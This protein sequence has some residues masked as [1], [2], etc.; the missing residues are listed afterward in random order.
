MR[1][2]V[3]GVLGLAGMCAAVACGSTDSGSDA[4]GGG[5]SANAPG[6]T[7]GETSGAGHAAGA[8]VAA[9]AETTA[10]AAGDAPIECEGTPLACD[11]VSGQEECEHSQGC[12][13]NSDASSCGEDPNSPRVAECAG[14]SPNECG[15]VAGCYWPEDLGL[16]N[17][18]LQYTEAS[19]WLLTYYGGIGFDCSSGPKLGGRS[20]TCC[21]VRCTT[22][23][24]C[25][26]ASRAMYCYTSSGGDISHCAPGS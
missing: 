5:G 8:P 14:V 24:D 21:T 10:G 19:P 16:C 9:P 3:L 6:R 26:G 12:L 17:R 2:L 13:W 22:D 7:G 15:A 4:T 18:N 1:C 20:S 23:A 25:A 11:V